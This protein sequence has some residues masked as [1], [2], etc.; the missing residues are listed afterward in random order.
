MKKT[1]P[2]FASMLL[3]AASANAAAEKPHIELD[4]I[5]LQIFEDVQGGITTA[6]IIHCNFY[7]LIYVY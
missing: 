7:L 1:L 6:K 3:A 5:D 4:D 2:L